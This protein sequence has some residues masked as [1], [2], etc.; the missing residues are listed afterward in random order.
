MKKN[1]VLLLTLLTIISCG[2]TKEDTVLTDYVCA[3]DSFAMVM[4]KIGSDTESDWAADTVHAMATEILNGNYS[5]NE[6]LARIYQMNNYIA[7]GMCYFS[8][9]IGTNH[10][11]ETADYALKIIETSDS[12]YSSIADKGFKDSFAIMELGYMSYFNLCMFAHL[13]NEIQ[14]AKD[15]GQIF[16]DNIG[17]P[18]QGMNMLLELKHKGYSQHDLE[19]ISAPLEAAAF[20]NTFCPLIQFFAHSKEE[21]LDETKAK[22]LEIAAYFDEHTNPMFQE[23]PKPMTDEDY[24]RFIVKSTKYKTEMLRMLTEDV[25]RMK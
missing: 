9:V 4:P 1:F 15:G 25:S 18:L 3:L 23:N 6:N 11:P 16:Q 21:S 20:F 10:D 22:V 8:A 24:K 7:Y 13:Q 19:K 2:C 12:V 14:K 5:E 17:A